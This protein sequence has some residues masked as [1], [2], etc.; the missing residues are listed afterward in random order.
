MNTY[1]RIS[2]LLLFSSLIF[3]AGCAEKRMTGLDSDFG[4]SY[5]LSKYNQVLNPEAER[6]LEPVTGIGVDESVVIV[7]Q[8]FKT[9]ERSKKECGYTFSFKR[10]Y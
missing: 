3:C 2:I 1:I 6:N 7:Q 10:N 4:S 5:R 9:F 8:Y